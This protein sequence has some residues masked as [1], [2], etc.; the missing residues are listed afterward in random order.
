MR[1]R[2]GKDY[3]LRLSLDD[4]NASL[5]VNN[6]KTVTFNFETKLNEGEL[7]FG[8]HNASCHFDD[9]EIFTYSGIQPL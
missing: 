3:T 4:G 7:G 8:A 2:K 6:R 9:V 5:V 1:I